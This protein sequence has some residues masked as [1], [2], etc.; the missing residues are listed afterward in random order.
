MS[1]ARLLSDYWY[2]YQQVLVAAAATEAVTAGT[3]TAFDLQ[4]SS[5][6]FK[7]LLGLDR[8]DKAEKQQLAIDPLSLPIPVRDRLARLASAT[9]PGLW[10]RCAGFFKASGAHSAARPRAAKLIAELLHNNITSAHTVLRIA[11][12]ELPDLRTLAGQDVLI[13]AISALAASLRGP[14][15]RRA[16]LQAIGAFAAQ[17]P[18]LFEKWRALEFALV[19]PLLDWIPV[20]VGDPGQDDD[21]PGAMMPVI[22]DIERS[23]P[24]ADREQEPLTEIVGILGDRGDALWNSADRARDAAV[25]LWLNRHKNY[26]ETHRIQVENAKVVIDLQLVTGIG[27]GLAGLRTSIRAHIVLT[28]SSLE[29]PLALGIY[30]RI[31]GLR[32]S[33]EVRS[34]G[35]LGRYKPDEQGGGGDTPIRPVAGIAGKALAADAQLADRMIMPFGSAPVEGEGLIL[36]ARTLGAAVDLAFGDADG[37]RFVRA[38]DIAAGC[39]RAP[40]SIHEKRQIRDQL[41]RDDDVVADLAAPPDLVAAAL[42]SVNASISKEGGY[43]SNG[44]YTFVRLSATERADA[45]WSTIW[46]A[47]DG[48][49]KELEEFIWASS[50][51]ERAAIFA[52]QLSRRR[53]SLEDPRFS[54]HVLV[55]I[56]VGPPTR[57]LGLPGGLH[58]R[59]DIRR[60]A[61]KLNRYLSARES[62]ADPRLR[63]RLGATR[64]VLVHSDGLPIDQPELPNST[65]EAIRSAVEQLAAFRFGFTFAMACRQ[66]VDSG[67]APVTP[68]Y[69]QDLLEEMR[70]TRL[71]DGSPLLVVGV[72]NLHRLNAAPIAFEM[73]LSRRVLPPS[74]SGRLELHERAA[75]A[76][77]PLLRPGSKASHVELSIGF[78]A[79]WLDEAIVQIGL[80]RASAR[81]VGAARQRVLNLKSDLMRLLRISGTPILERLPV[82][83][84]RHG[85]E[86]AYLDFVDRLQ[87]QHHP[88]LHV[89][90]ATMATT[91]A[92]DPANAPEVRG[93]FYSAALQHLQRAEEALRWVATEEERK[94]S[95]FLIAT[96]RCRIGWT[97]RHLPLEERPIREH[98]QWVFDRARD[99]LRYMR[100]IYWHDWF[101]YAGDFEIDD[102]LARDI[103]GAGLWN[104]SL[105]ARVSSDRLIV[106]WTGTFSLVEFIPLGNVAWLKNHADR[107]FWRY[108]T[109]EQAEDDAALLRATAHRWWGGVTRIQRL[110]GAR[111]PPP[112]RPSGDWRTRTSEFSSSTQGQ[113]HP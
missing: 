37:H 33:A 57:P 73:M 42:I 110:S 94:G 99:L 54:P 3:A 36:H 101:Q 100:E 89:R 6:L 7:G 69:C 81:A 31:A 50:D 19:Q 35:A 39:K 28:G 108:V 88:T 13:D 84:G 61:Q 14:R 104:D 102:W 29:L 113:L 87:R 10:Q 53:P 5:L 43:G 22:I 38:A 15:T 40:Y 93:G 4:W 64:L 25:Q 82:L 98:L 18:A 47:I 68:R 90:A 8:A 20:V 85:D 72:T 95:A 21:M 106:K 58:A 45:A 30:E 12:Q 107:R 74:P 86:A 55:I 41:V 59:F 63:R 77:V 83:A 1:S 60:I 32:R 112:R 80:A 91:L 46:S 71:S 27:F 2:R 103:Y 49:L 44:R 97:T 76:I 78:S 24:L 23:A 48:D 92:Q 9:G 51:D 26:P 67:G 79:P 52:R 105:P 11:Q 16:K 96:E 56:G 75:F 34:S 111:I 17:V 109:S 66:L 70:R 62:P 65:D